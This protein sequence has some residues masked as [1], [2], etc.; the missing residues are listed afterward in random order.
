LLLEPPLV[1]VNRLASVAR[2]LAGSLISLT[3]LSAGGT[4]T[5][6]VDMLRICSLFAG[7]VSTVALC[8]MQ[9]TPLDCR[10]LLPAE[11]PTAYGSRHNSERCEGIFRPAVA[12]GGTG[13]DLVSLTY[14]PVSYNLS[15]DRELELSI[16]TASRPVQLVGTGLVAGLFYRMSASYG[17]T[18]IHV[19]LADVLSPEHIS[20]EKVGFYAWRSIPGALTSFLPVRV[21]S[22]SYQG[23]PTEIHA[24]IRPRTDIESI[25]WRVRDPQASTGA[26][27][28]LAAS[29]VLKGELFSIAFD[30]AAHMSVVLDVAYKTFP[31]REHAPVLFDITLR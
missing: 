26:F 19:P 29:V 28:T 20:P 31:E 30:P 10:D 27:S 12:G 15:T 3:G 21:K 1:A 24:V 18:S 2:R 14:G 5:R 16:D 13:L 23:Q 9:A 7:C 22:A 4:M 11:G 17:S 8:A 6:S 25:R